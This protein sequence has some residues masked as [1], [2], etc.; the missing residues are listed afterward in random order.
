MVYDGY[1]GR[2]VPAGSAS[3]DVSLDP[4]AVVLLPL[5]FLETQRVVAESMER[6]EQARAARRVRPRCDARDHR[7]STVIR[8]NDGL[9]ALCDE[10]RGDVDLAML[11]SPR[12]L[13]LLVSR[14]DERKQGKRR[15]TLER[16]LAARRQERDLASGGIGRC[17]L[18]GRFRR[19]LETRDGVHLACRGCAL[20]VPITEL[21]GR[22][23]VQALVERRSSG[24][25]SSLLAAVADRFPSLV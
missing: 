11:E 21:D 3:F 10:C 12:L 18:C 4:E 1:F 25:R 8:A 5:S 16:R 23:A 9:L 22:V 14:V 20:G 19:I 15:R 24:A 6:R 13:E 2:F 17:P 7:V